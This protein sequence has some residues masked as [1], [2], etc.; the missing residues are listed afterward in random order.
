MSLTGERITNT[1]DPFTPFDGN[2][3][4]EAEKI[5]NDDVK[6]L[7]NLQP[8]EQFV[9]SNDDGTKTLLKGCR[10]VHN[11]GEDRIDTFDYLYLFDIGDDDTLAGFGVVS[12]FVDTEYEDMK[13]RPFVDY[14]RTSEE[15]RRQGLGRRRLINMNAASQQFFNLPLYSSRVI[16]DDAL[17]LWQDL[18]QEGLVIQDRGSYR[19]KTE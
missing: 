12:M 1:T 8:S 9:I 7:D 17:R 5:F 10:G 2:L 11:G 4:P 19:F 6:R 13:D 3:P 14:T 16:Q 18:E 15:Y